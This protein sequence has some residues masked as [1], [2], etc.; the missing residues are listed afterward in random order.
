MLYVAHPK[1]SQ[2]EWNEYWREYWDSTRELA[3]GRWD[4]IFVALA[5]GLADAVSRRGKGHVPCPVHG[6]TD[7]FRVFQSFAKD[8]RSICNT[9]GHFHDGFETLSWVNAWTKRETVEAVRGYL[10]GDSKHSKAPSVRRELPPKA[11]V[12]PRRSDDSIRESLNRTMQRVSPMSAPQAAPVRR[13][14]AERG[15]KRSMTNALLYHP[16]LAYSNGKSI[17]GYHPAMVAV[18][19][20]ANGQPVTLHRTYLDEFGHKADVSAAK[21]LM[22]YPADRKLLG[23]AIRLARPGKV[24][25]VAEGIETS[26]AAMEG[27]GIPVWS[28]VNA[29]MLEHFVP[30]ED[31]ELVIVF[32]DKDRPTEQH[33]RGHGQEAASAL[34]KRMWSIGKKAIAITPKGEIPDGQKSLDWLDILNRDGVKG[35]PP[36]E[37]VKRAAF[38]HA[39]GI[40]A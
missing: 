33:P 8:G 14:L 31:V 29:T 10:T 21:K 25:G 5:P 26:L 35:F 9:C 11:A 27:M 6:G 19:Q 30:P 15:L 3:D 34:V 22:E 2:E 32:S 16:R 12:A 24:L 13:Y 4:S 39:F 20:A 1:R 28:T 17:T 40:A 36:L 38:E 18:V 37:A 23:G 7:G